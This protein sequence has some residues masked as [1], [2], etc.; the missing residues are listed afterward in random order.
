MK[1][2]TAMLSGSE[3]ITLGLI[4]VIDTG[5]RHDIEHTRE[6]FLRPHGSPPS[7]QHE[8][9]EAERASA[10]ETLDEGSHCFSGAETLQRQG[11]PER[12]IVNAAV[13]W[14][15]DLVIVCPRGE[16]GGTPRVGPK[17]IGHTARFVLDHAP[18]PVLLMR[19]P[20]QGP[21]PRQ[22]R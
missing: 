13:E 10:K 11:T 8:M 22:F 6:R 14:Q 16:Y 2:A 1:R 9:D 3:P 15:A 20:N 19:P 4:Y 17:S 18:C 12:E 21:F 5:A 7:R